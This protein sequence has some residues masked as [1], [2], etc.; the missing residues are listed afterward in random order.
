MNISDCSNEVLAWFRETEGVFSYKKASEV[1]GPVVEDTEERDAVLKASLQFLEDCEL[2]KKV[3]IESRDFWVLKKRVES[4]SQTIEINETLA[5]GIAEEINT[6]CEAI[7]D[8]SDR[9]SAADI[10]EKDIKNL[11][12]MYVHAKNT[13]TKEEKE[14]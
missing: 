5:L 1:L 12:I 6:F 10:R 13:L 7:K 11:L 8:H 3:S 9:C 14:E 2:I 4:Y